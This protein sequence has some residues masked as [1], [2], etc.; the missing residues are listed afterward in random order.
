MI[1]DSGCALINYHGIEISSSKSNCSIEN[2]A[3]NNAGKPLHIQ[4]Y[5]TQPFHHAPN[6][7]PIGLCV[8]LAT[9]F[10]MAWYNMQCSLV[11]YHGIPLHL[12]LEVPWYTHSP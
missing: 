1:V 9:V 7:C 10:C 8:V 12:S 6:V 11:V 2:T 3:T 5:L 4:Q